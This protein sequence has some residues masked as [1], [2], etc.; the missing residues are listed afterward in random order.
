MFITFSQPTNNEMIHRFV[1]VELLLLDNVAWFIQPLETLVPTE[2]R[3][4]DTF[5]DIRSICKYTD[6]KNHCKHVRMH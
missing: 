4:Y 2:Q 3:T 1:S 5:E 6:H